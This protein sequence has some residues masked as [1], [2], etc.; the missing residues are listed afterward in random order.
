MHVLLNNPIGQVSIIRRQATLPDN[1]IDQI[2]FFRLI[3]VLYSI[4]QKAPI[5]LT[6][7]GNL[8]LNV[9]SHLYEQK[10]LLQDDI[11][12][13][14]TKKISEDNVVFIQALKA[15]LLVGPDVKKRG[16]G[17]FRPSLR[18]RVGTVLKTMINGR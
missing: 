6:S 16:N 9:C 5:K 10:F 18:P 12:K 8:P 17:G 15:C 11:E 14:Y 13:G 7:K 4:L 3:D 2:P 1:I